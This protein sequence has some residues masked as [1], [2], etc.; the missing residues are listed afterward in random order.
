MG[1]DGRPTKRSFGEWLTPWLKALSRM[2]GLRG[3][4]LDVFGYT[5][6]RKMER[7]LIKQYEADMRKLLPSLSDGTRDAMVALAELPMQIRGFGP[8]KAANEA[9]AAKRREE[10]LAAIQ[11]GGSAMDHAAE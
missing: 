10:L 3:T 9:K 11:S 5:Q 4:P 8:V 2:K 6:E 1:S 7:A